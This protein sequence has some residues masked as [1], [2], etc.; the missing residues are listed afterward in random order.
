MGL[1]MVVHVWGKEAGIWDGGRK[2][3][4]RRQWGCSKIEGTCMAG[5]RN[6]ERW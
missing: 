5:E 3:S 4:E 1:D 6:D 2:R